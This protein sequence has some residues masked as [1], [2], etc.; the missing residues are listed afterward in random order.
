MTTRS[1]FT[2][3]SCSTRFIWRLSEHIRHIVTG[4]LWM[5]QYASLKRN[6]VGHTRPVRCDGMRNQK[7]L[8][9]YR[10]PSA[11]RIDLP[12]YIRVEPLHN[13]NIIRIRNHSKPMCGGRLLH[14]FVH[15][16]P[17]RM[18]RGM[19]SIAFRSE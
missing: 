3:T 15:C 9:C 19:T 6:M 16:L 7:R 2:S 13:L 11:M 5:P 1:T 8:Y 12:N 17:D 14:V 10:N 18:S 4:S